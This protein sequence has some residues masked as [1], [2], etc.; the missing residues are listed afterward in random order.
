MEMRHVQLAGDIDGQCAPRLQLRANAQQHPPHIR[1]HKDRICRPLRIGRAM[2][3]APLE[4]LAGIGAGGLKRVFRQPK[5]LQPD[6]QTLVVHHREHAGEPF[7]GFSHQETSGSVEVDHARGRSLDAHLVFDGTAGHAIELAASLGQLPG[8]QE[9]GNPLRARGRIRQARQ[10]QMNDVVAQVVLP[11]RDEY[12]GAGNQVGAVLR[13]HRAGLEK[14][15][16]CA[17]MGFRQAHGAS[18]FA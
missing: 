9:Q 5:A 3:R 13:G 12:L 1:M 4:A 6:G 8:H 18:P 15:Q 7:V 10:H 17:R 14:A 11:A 16:I 2:C